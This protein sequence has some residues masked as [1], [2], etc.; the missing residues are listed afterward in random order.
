MKAYIDEHPDLDEETKRRM[1]K[2]YEKSKKAY[3]K[4]V[5]IAYYTSKKFFAD[6]SKAALKTGYKMGLRQA[7]GFVLSEIWFAVKEEFQ[8]AKDSAESLLRAIGNGIKR[9]LENAKKRYKEIWHMFIEGS[10]AGLLS[11]LTTTLCNIFFTTAKN[12]VRII[13]QSWASLVEAT[14]IIIFNPDCLPFG[15]RFRAG[16]KI[17]ATGASV[18][19]GTMVSEL[20]S[21]TAIGTMPVVGGILQTF[22][23]T[24]VSGIMSCTFL[25]VLDHN[26]AVGKIVEILNSVPTVDDIVRG[27]KEQG[28]LLEVYCARLMS[29]DND[30]FRQEVADCYKVAGLLEAATNE[31]ELSRN[32]ATIY[33]MLNIESPF[34]NHEG[35]DSFMNDPTAV[36]K[37]Q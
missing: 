12:I 8:K 30:K 5:N 33:Q 6:T 23:G 7:L 29:I 13:R 10:I 28:Q 18:V 36:L 22:C 20:I 4:Q 2:Q 27:Y 14:K 24:L 21:K 19:A 1:L 31:E 16:T 25:Y 37:F 15:E 11:S 17:L 32:L 34:G 3:E 9:G 35:I 26:S